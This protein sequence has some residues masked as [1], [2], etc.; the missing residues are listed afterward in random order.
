MTLTQEQRLDLLKVEMQLLQTVFNKYD[1]MMFRSRNWFITLWAATIGFSFTIKTPVVALA[2]SGL[3]LLYWF[4]EGNIRSQHWYKY[5]VRYRVLREAL[6]KEPFALED[7]TLYDL[8]HHLGKE[9]PSWVLRNWE[10]YGRFEPLVVY[11]SLGAVAIFSWWSMSHGL[12][13]LP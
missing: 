10:S 5:V 1:D 6:N 9:K 2:A 4:F 7:L 11:G 12:I 13:H 3:A 8:T